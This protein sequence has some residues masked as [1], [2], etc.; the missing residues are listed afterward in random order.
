MEAPEHRACRTRTTGEMAA[1][2]KAQQRRQHWPTAAEI[3]ADAGQ[4]EPD[5]ART[6][7][8]CDK[9]CPHHNRRCSQAHTDDI[10]H[11][12]IWC[13]TGTESFARTGPHGTPET[14]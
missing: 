6:P 7:D 9:V 4:T 2:L 8:L 12:C 11:A 1:W 14:L 13:T 3:Y 10:G 5:W